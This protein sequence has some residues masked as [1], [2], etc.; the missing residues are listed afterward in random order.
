MITAFAKHSFSKTKIPF[1]KRKGN[2]CFTKSFYISMFSFGISIGYTERP[3]SCDSFLF[4][5]KNRIQND[6]CFIF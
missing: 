1:L 3:F 5:N 2:F 6:Y 4:Y